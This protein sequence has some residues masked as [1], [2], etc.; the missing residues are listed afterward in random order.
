VGDA[1]LAH[2]GRMLVRLIVAIAAAA[3]LGLV[4]GSPAWATVSEFGFVTARDGTKLRYNVVRPDGPGPF[5]VVINY[6]GYGAGSNAGDNGV[7]VYQDRLLKRGY[8][9]MGLSVR[10]TGC[11]EGIFDPFVPTMGTDGYD[12]V[13]W[14][15]RQPWSNGRV[16]MIG[17]SFGGLTQLFT[18]A[19]RPPHLVA[20]AP[21]SA[22][23]DL[24]RDVAYPGGILNYQFTAFFIAIQRAA[25]FEGGGASNEAAHPECA[26]IYAQHEAA[27]ADPNYLGAK[28]VLENPYAD[29]SNGSTYTWPVRSA[30][31]GF[32]NIDVPMMYFGTWQD[33]QLPARIFE[34]LGAFPHPERVWANLSN[35]E[36]GR[37]Y[38]SPTDQQLTLDFL[39]RFVGREKNGFTQKVPHLA[40][41]META[42]ERNGLSNEPA[43][44]I[45]GSIK[46][47]SLDQLGTVAS[48]S[49]LDSGGRL[50]DSAPSGPQTGDSYAYPAPSS[51]EAEPG[52]AEQ[53]HTTDQVAWKAPV[54]PG[55]AVAY[56]SA[57]LAKDKVVLGPASLDLWLASTATDT[58]IQATITEVRPDGQEVY[59]QRGWLR[60]SQR[61]LDPALST[62]VRPY[63]THRRADA[64]PLVP[65]QPT[66]MRVEIFPFAHAFRKGSRI[67]VWIEAPTEHT[68]LWAFTFTPQPA[69]DT[70]LHDAAHPSRLVLGVLPGQVAQAPLPACDTLRNQPCR[71]DPLAK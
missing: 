70:V 47:G 59:V 18:A 36:H 71:T 13:E 67:R 11:S 46:R 5:P 65:G 21:S 30:I 7:S 44:N 1:G 26:P 22:L 8:A 52:P 34:S 43:W 9:L 54:P 2:G 17:V 58:D 37:D 48:A 66:D 15:A 49:Y 16:G 4:G 60:A 55:G 35:G 10:G 41:A 23:S 40:I 69:T 3:T 32:K 64:Q 29:D 12:A 38:F 51:N 20:I 33:E 57:A 42:I 53:G 39:D 45:T 61:K 14:A 6:E 50:T 68:G 19:T 27:N 28:L 25:Y 24:Y 62:A 56:T 63:Q 31:T